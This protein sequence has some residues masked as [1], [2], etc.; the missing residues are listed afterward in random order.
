MS[1]YSFEFKKKVVKAYLSGE[2]GSKYLSKTYGVPSRRS[3]EEWVHNYQE[4]GDEGLIRS[5]MNQTYS[6]EKKLSVVELYLSSEISYQDL[7]LQEGI[8][9]PSMIVNW[10]NRFRVAGPEA[11][12]PHKKGRRKTLE[13]PEKKPSA[14]PIE[15]PVDTSAEH[16]KELEDELLKLRIEN[17][18]LKELRR[19]RLEDEAKM[20]ERRESSTASED[21]FKLKDLLSYTCMPKATFMYWQKRF[22]RENPD[23]VL[24]ETILA[25]RECN[26]DYGYRRIVGEL[27]NQG[28]K[29]NKKKVQRIMQKLGLQVTSFTRKSRKYSSYKGKV[30]TVAP[31]RIKRRFNTHIP[32]QKITTDTTELK[33]YEV[34]TKGHM[35]MHKLYLDPFMDMCNGEILSFGIDKH[36]SVK[37]VMDALEQ[38]IEITSDCPYRRTFH[39][40]Q[41][42][43]YQMKAYSHRLKQE[44]I[45]QSM[46]RKGNCLDNSVMENFFGLL[47][48]EIYYGVVYY[49]YEELKSEIERYIK[50]YNEQRIKE[51]LGWM[52][53]VQ[54]RLNLLAA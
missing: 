32:H 15:S 13:K 5:R 17:A 42:W 34:D 35:T 46:S 50:Y 44:R 41:G 9:N 29:V 24:E 7:A 1:K 14:L 12:R 36:P 19:L 48:Q 20:R 10:V 37:N 2:G 4:F 16:V 27:H 47:K 38:A 28:I 45:F 26:K 6:F 18:F 30:G 23:K 11:L 25:I 54:Y 43:A 31:N 3:I 49:S 51:K 21:K 53:P 8:T 33:Y 52:S 40:D 39:S 22:D